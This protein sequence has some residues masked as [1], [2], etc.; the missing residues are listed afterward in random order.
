MQ[1][2]LKLPNAAELYLVVGSVLERFAYLTALPLN[3]RTPEMPLCYRSAMPGDRGWLVLRGTA[4]LAA[5]IA[6]ART[7]CSGED[8][9]HNAFIELCRISASQ[10]AEKIW[11]EPSDHWA[12]ASPQPGLPQGRPDASQVLDLN[13]QA[14][15]VSF[16]TAS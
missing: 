10:L 11:N 13:G 1:G 14:L 9:G 7:G 8:L 2:A 16:W 12:T 5:V 15:E 4:G 6:E 3:D